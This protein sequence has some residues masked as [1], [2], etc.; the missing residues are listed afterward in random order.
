MVSMRERLFSVE[1]TFVLFFGH[2]PRSGAEIDKAIA[3][4]RDGAE[5]V[6]L[7]RPDEESGDLD[8]KVRMMKVSKPPASP[9]RAAPPPDTRRSVPEAGRRPAECG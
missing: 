7:I 5:K 6:Q 8:R 1:L 2:R 3:S 9:P 4:V